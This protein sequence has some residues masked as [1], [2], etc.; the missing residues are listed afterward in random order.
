MIAIIA[1]AATVMAFFF[2]SLLRYPPHFITCR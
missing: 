1:W 2:A